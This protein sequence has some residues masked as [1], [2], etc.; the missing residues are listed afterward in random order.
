MPVTPFNEQGVGFGY[1]HL[2]A[3]SVVHF[4]VLAAISMQIALALVTNVL[5]G[6]VELGA[7]IF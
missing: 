6:D 5:D 3:N 4:R 7:H 2:R 1:H